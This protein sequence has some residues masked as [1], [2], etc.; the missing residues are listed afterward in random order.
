MH[1]VGFAVPFAFAAVAA[2]A[3]PV[4]GHLAG[5]RLND[6][7][8]SKLAA[9]ELATETETRA[10]LIVGGALVD[11]EVRYGVEIPLLGSL[12]SRG[13]VDAELVGLDD[14]P[15]G[16]EVPATIVHTSFQLMVALGT[17]LAALGIVYWWL[18]RRGRDL[19]ERTW[20]RWLV[21][22]SGPA[23]ITALLA[24]WITTEV[25]R[26][27]WIAYRV[28]RVDEAVTDASWLWLSFGTIVVVYGSMTYFGIRI[29][30]SMVHRWNAG[31]TDIGAPYGPG[32]HLSRIGANGGSDDADP[33]SRTRKE[34]S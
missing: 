16:D 20:F 28:M 1:R 34:P 19:I 12:I 8:P 11:G 2:I 5:L 17:G 21:S 13:S 31:E 27:P 33:R 10:P 9:M 32:E 15:E 22:A 18:R 6:A 7:Q 14:L 3:Q 24:G 23:A 25:G 26:Q 30:R 29:I 4:V